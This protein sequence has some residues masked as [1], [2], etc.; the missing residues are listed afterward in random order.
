MRRHPGFFVISR[1]PT[2]QGLLIKFPG[3]VPS[4]LAGGEAAGVT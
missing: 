4:G 1:W 3:R 2:F